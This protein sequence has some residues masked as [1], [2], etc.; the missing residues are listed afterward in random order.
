MVAVTIGGWATQLIVDTGAT[1]HLLTKD[2]VDR[3]GLHMAAAADGRDA[4]GD[5]VPSWTVGDIVVDIGM[6]NHTLRD[7]VAIDAPEPFLGWGV[8]GFLSPQLLAPNA[9]VVLDLM[10]NRIDIMDGEA[11]VVVAD[12]VRRFDHLALEA[13]VR[14]AAGTIGIEVRVPP[15]SPVVAIFDT[16]A[17]ETDIAARA[18]GTTAEG[19]R[20]AS[21]RG[22]GGSEIETAVLEDQRLEVGTTRLKV[23]ALG[24]RPEIPPPDDAAEGEI[25]LALIGMDVLRGTAVVIAPR[26]HGSVWW[27]VSNDED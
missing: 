19:I 2:L 6:S 21:G 3:A 20:R 4:A 27:L 5:S 14:H 8:G 22:V 13:G 10:Q 11:T 26:D 17:A 16:G 18:L 12:L 1:C 25:P 24:V 15:A 7:V 9:T 23:P